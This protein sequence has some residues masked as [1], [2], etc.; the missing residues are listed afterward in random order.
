MLAGVEVDDGLRQRA[1]QTGYRTAHQ[2]ETRAG[3][4][5]RGLEVEPAVLLAEGE[6]ILD[7]AK[8]NAR[9]APSSLYLDVVVFAGPYRHRGVRQVG[10]VSSRIQLGLDGI[11]LRS[12]AASSP[13]RAPTSAISGAHARHA[14]GLADA[15]PASIAPA[16][17]CSVRV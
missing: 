6:M 1:V 14:A 12:A 17:S 13:P 10:M 8:S 4:L 16:C 3:Q 9:G 5:G 7:L 2:R 11:Q 15:L